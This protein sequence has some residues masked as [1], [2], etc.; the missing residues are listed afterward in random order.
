VTHRRGSIYI[1]DGYGNHRVVVF[2]DNAATRPGCG[3]GSGVATTMN[4]VTDSPGLFASGDGGH[5]HC[6]IGSYDTSCMSATAPTTA[7]RSSTSWATCSV[8]PVVP[9]TGVTLGIGGVPGLG[10][11]GS[12][13]NVAFSNDRAQSLMFEADGGNEIVHIMDRVMGAIRGD[14]GAP[15]LQ[16]GQFSS[17]TRVEGSKGSLCTGETS[18]A[19]ACRSSC[20][21][22]PGKGQGN[23]K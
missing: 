8:G 21:R 14:F 20:L 6:V 22:G 11:A 23:C 18:T 4:V 3:N 5:P 13:W 2:Q 1:A 12:A 10:T 7:S 16:A 15:G 19:A 17:R 9:G